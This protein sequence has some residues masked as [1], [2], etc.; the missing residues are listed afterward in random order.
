MFIEYDGRI[1]GP[2]SGGQCLIWLLRL[3]QHI[4]LLTE[5]DGLGDVVYKHCPPDGGPITPA[6]DGLESTS[7][8][9]TTLNRY[10]SEIDTTPRALA[11]ETPGYRGW[12]ATGGGGCVF[13]CCFK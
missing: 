9:D 12:P 2:P 5:G 10:D 8:V 3:N 1:P 6:K 4:A 11:F 7:L 13:T